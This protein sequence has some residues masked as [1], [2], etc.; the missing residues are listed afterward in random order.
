MLTWKAQMGRNQPVRKADVM[1]IQKIMP[2]S[3]MT[4]KKIP[5]SRAMQAGAR[6]D[7]MSIVQA[8]YRV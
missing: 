4:K 8:W 3:M 6:V 2:L 7:R 1:L 5:Q